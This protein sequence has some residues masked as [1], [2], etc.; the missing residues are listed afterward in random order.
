MDR[1]QPALP[2]VVRAVEPAKP[3]AARPTGA[4]DEGGDCEAVDHDLDS[5]ADALVW[6]GLPKAFELRSIGVSFI[7]LSLELPSTRLGSADRLR[8]S[9]A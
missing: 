7:S 8:T 3:F 1:A 2:V 4:V 5:A 9:S 6:A